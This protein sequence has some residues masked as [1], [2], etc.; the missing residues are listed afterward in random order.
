MNEFQDNLIEQN[1]KKPAVAPLVLGILSFTGI[2]LA[3]FGYIFGIIGL[4]LSV[5][6]RKQP[7]SKYGTAGMVL[8]IIGLVVTVINSIIGAIMMMNMMR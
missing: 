8:S 7:N 5:K 3:I 2:L 6:D 4:V 1:E